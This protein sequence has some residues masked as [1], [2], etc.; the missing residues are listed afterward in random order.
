LGYKKGNSSVTLFSKTNRDNNTNALSHKFGTSVYHKFASCTSCSC[1]PVLAVEAIY[2]HQSSAVDLGAGASCKP[3]ATST[4]K[5]KVSNKGQLNVAFNKDLEKPL[6]LGLFAQT[7][8]FNLSEVK[9][10][11]KLAYTQ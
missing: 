2:N 8:L 11:V 7:D 5:A 3:D 10:G 9:L 6:S 4:M 1:N